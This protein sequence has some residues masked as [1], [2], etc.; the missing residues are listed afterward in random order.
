[1]DSPLVQRSLSALSLAKFS[2]SATATGRYANIGSSIIYAAWNRRNLEKIYEKNNNYFITDS[3]S[4]CF[5][6]NLAN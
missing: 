5:Q 2:G 6:P 3:L 4:V 1:M